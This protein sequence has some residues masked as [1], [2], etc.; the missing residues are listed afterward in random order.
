MYET[1]AVTIQPL[2]AATT[3]TLNTSLNAQLPKG[4]TPTA[5]A[6]KGA[7]LQAYSWA[8]AHTDHTVI[9]VLATDGLPTTEC[10]APG[11]VPAGGAITEVTGIATQGVQSGIKTFVIGVFGP[12]DPTDAAMNLGNIAT[13]GGSPMAYIVDTTQD[14]TQQFLAALNAI[15]STGLACEFQIPDPPAGGAALDYNRVNVSFTDSGTNTVVGKAQD[16]GATTGVP[17]DAAGGWHYDVDPASGK[18][19]K[20]IACPAS[21]DSFQKSV[22]GSVSIVLGC[23]T[24]P[25]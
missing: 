24:Q 3:T 1:P 8:M 14:V 7:I 19:T 13:A 4:A 22:G 17:C 5:P 18:P 12:D 21:C 23:Q 10:E 9:T 20:I 11:T 15:R 25:K 2:S 16:P 6:L